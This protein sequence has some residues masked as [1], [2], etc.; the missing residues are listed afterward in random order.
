[1]GN[2]VAG[3]PFGRISLKADRITSCDAVHDPECPNIPKTIGEHLR[4]RR[5]Q[6][7][8]TF[9]QLVNRLGVDLHLIRAWEEDRS[10]PGG[11][12]LR[13]VIGW[14]GYDPRAGS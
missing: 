10:V 3:L 9:R 11:D 5:I 1:M 4:K 13:R 6:T 7:G 2:L 12:S 8:I 14:L